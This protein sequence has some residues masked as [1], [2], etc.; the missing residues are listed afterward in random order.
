MLLAGAGR[1]AIGRWGA[2]DTWGGISLWE[3]LGNGVTL[4]PARGS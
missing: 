1:R 3:I 4:P 2:M